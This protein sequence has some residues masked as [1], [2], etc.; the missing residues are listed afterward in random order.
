MVLDFIEVRNM[1][2]L[3][4]E[5][6]VIA[7]LGCNAPYTSRKGIVKMV[8]KEPAPRF[9]VSQAEAQRVI[10]KMRKG[11]PPERSGLKCWM[12]QE[13]YGIYKKLKSEHSDLGQVELVEMAI[14][15][16]ASS[17]FLDEAHVY[18]LLNK[19]K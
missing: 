13:L 14:N 12:Y 3:K 1:D 18:Y 4:A 8:S 9:Y 5:K 11:L 2:L 17:F 10:S 7:R 19:K 6:T 16:P 15:S